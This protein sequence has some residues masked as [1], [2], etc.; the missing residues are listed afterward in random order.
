MSLVSTFSLVDS[1]LALAKAEPFSHVKNMTKGYDEV[2]L[3]PCPQKIV[4]DLEQVL[5]H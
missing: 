5:L 1:L 4:I 3:P 2:R